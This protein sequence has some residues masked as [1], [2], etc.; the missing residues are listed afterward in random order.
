MALD[1]ATLRVAFAVVGLAL[2]ILF[3]VVTYRRTRAPYGAWWCAAIALFLSGS[4]VYLF[5]EDGLQWWVNPLGNVLLVLGMAS[6]WTGARS[7]HARKP[8]VWAL[9][10]GAA[11]TAGSAAANNPAVNGLAGEPVF[12]ALMS[13]FI[14]L[15]ATELFL[16]RRGFTRLRVPMSLAAGFLSAFYL[17]RLVTFLTDGEDGPIYQAFFGPASTTIVTLALMVVV[18]FSMATFSTEQTA[19]D[20]RKRALH[21]GLTG[22][23]NRNAFLDLATEM[24]AERPRNGRGGALVLADLDHFKSI[25]DTHG[26]PAGDKALRAF[27]SVCTDTVRSTDLVGRYGGEEFILLLAGVSPEQAQRVVHD[28]RRNLRNADFPDFTLPTVSFGIAAVG[29]DGTEPTRW[30]PRSMPQTPHSTGQSP[31]AAT[32]PSL[33]ATATA[34]RTNCPVAEQPGPDSRLPTH[35]LSLTCSYTP[36]PPRQSKSCGILSA[37]ATPSN[38]AGSMG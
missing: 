37:P 3:Y 1:T 4:A 35:R 36:F 15:A 17:S 20:L 10:V 13:L 8:L 24:L 14:G 26:H 30:I 34:A 38:I 12:F 6:V 16:L 9:A 33:P 29:E 31:R 11:L 19:R 22:L 25:N 28:I 32:G 5:N 2:L 27:A 21:D 18:S 7:L 23:L